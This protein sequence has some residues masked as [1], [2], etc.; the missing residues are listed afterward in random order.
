MQALANPTRF[1]AI[2]ATLQP[3]LWGATAILFAAGLYLALVQ[4]PVD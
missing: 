1:L 4:A 2:Q 3:W